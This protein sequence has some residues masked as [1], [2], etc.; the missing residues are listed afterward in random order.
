MRDWTKKVGD[1][2]DWARNKVEDGRFGSKM[3][4]G[5]AKLREYAGAPIWEQGDWPKKRF[6]AV[7]FFQE[8]HF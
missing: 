5:A 7:G 1:L 6:G 8:N 4:A 2:G 3:G